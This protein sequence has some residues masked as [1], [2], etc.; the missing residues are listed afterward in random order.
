ME[1][2]SKGGRAVSSV[3]FRLRSPTVTRSEF[4]MRKS[5]RELIRCDDRTEFLER[6]ASIVALH[7]AENSREFM[8]MHAGVV[9]W[10]EQAIVLPGRSMSGKT[11]MVADLVRAGATYYSDDF[12]LID[13]QGRVYPYPRPLQIRDGRTHR[14]ASCP[15]EQLG[16][17]AGEAPLQIALVVLSQY[18]P[19]STWLPRELSPGVACLRMLDNTISARK[20]PEIALRSLRQV[21]GCA[22]AVQGVRGESSQVIQW[23]R[24]KVGPLAPRGSCSR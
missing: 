6:F 8:F 4:I 7:V 10:G 22:V 23:I 11:T 13:S 3:T 16:G 1:T 12:A 18:K 24:A 14:Q 15:V 17:L 2:D 20:A 21:A 5:G 19:Q 9:G